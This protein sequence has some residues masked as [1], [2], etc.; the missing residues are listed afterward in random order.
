MFAFCPYTLS[1]S[2]ELERFRVKGSGIRGVW[3]ANTGGH[4]KQ[5]ANIAS[6]TA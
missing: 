2:S 6:E 4:E 3:P 5:H 1:I